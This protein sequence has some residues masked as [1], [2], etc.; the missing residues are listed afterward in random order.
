MSRKDEI[1]DDDVDD[2]EVKVRATP[3]PPP[4][5]R[6]GSHVPFVMIVLGWSM[7]VCEDEEED[8]L[9]T[10]WMWCAQ[11]KKDSFCLVQK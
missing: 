4:S 9:M 6:F 7:V 11:K 3:P 10:P 8:S 2:V 5:L 1:C